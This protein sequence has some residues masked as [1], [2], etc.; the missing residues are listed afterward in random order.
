MRDLL[1]RSGTGLTALFCLLVA[2]WILVLVV[3]PNFAMFEQ[4]FRPYLPV[5]EVGG[6][7]DVYSFA[8]Y[9]KIVDN[10]I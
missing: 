1:R 5:T 4:S 8:N 2:F 10:P 9:L 6:P 7:R 3:L